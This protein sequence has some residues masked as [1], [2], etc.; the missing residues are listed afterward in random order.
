MIRNFKSKIAQDIF[1]GVM[2]ASARKIPLNLHE[3]IRRLFDQLNAATTVETLRIPPG[4]QLE[5][6]KGN[7]KEYWSIRTNK[8][9]RV[10]FVWKDSDAYNV[11]I[12]DYH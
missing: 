11:D 9:W 8:Q 3:K 6:L 1:D 7:L 10:I 5:K 2:S 4:N 12:I